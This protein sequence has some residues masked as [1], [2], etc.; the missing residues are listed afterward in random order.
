MMAQYDQLTELL[1]L[2]NVRVIHYQLVGPNRLNLFIESTLAAAMCPDCQQ[3]SCLVHDRG[4]PQFIRDLSIWNR[5][6]W[7]QYAPR[8]FACATC[9]T[10]FVERLAWREPT[11][12]YT[13]RYEQYLYERACQ[14]PVT[15]IAQAE[16]VSED[17]VQGIFERWAKKNLPSE[18]IPV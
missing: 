18:A 5:R 7:L 2:A 3:L 16:R 1:D 8:R 17:V 9:D 12:D 11:R 14:E 13:T 10:T 6:C 4:E 15:Q